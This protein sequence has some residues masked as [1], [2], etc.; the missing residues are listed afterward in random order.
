MV[1][2]IWEDH[3]HHHHPAVV[4]FVVVVV[5]SSFSNVFFFSASSRDTTKSVL[6]YY[7]IYSHTQKVFFHVWE[8]DKKTRERL[9]EKLVHEKKIK[10]IK[11]PKH[12]QKKR[13][14][15]KGADTL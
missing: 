1:P 7:S 8:R 10:K 2:Y 11:N 14:W 6:P 13:N 3:H 9:K 12:M 15:V 5:F 4:V